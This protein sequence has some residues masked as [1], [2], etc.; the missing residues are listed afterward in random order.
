MK[1]EKKLS[2]FLIDLRRLLNCHDDKES[3]KRQ[4]DELCFHNLGLF[5]F[6]VGFILAMHTS[7]F[8]HNRQKY[9]V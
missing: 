5:G 4:K 2:Y 9:S 3:Q 1:L 8:Y 6:A 7:R